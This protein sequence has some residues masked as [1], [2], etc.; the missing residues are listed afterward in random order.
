[1]TRPHT[2]D[3]QLPISKDL[4]KVPL[5]GVVS[6]SLTEVGFSKMAHPDATARPCQ[7]LEG[8]QVLH[9]LQTVGWRELMFANMWPSQEI[10]R[11]HARERVRG[12]HL[13]WGHLC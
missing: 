1:M 12:S 10:S 11:Y 5:L 13:V 9:R 4:Q 7:G 2:R 6:S 8:F 3:R